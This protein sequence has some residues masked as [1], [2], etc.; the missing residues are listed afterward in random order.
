M[1]NK[2]VISL[3]I[4]FTILTNS[5]G[6]ELNISSSE[7]EYNKNLS[8]WE[9]KKD[10]VIIDSKNNKVLAQEAL[11]DKEKQIITTSGITEVF[12]SDGYY[13]NSSNVVFDNIS[14]TITSNYPSEIKDKEGNLIKLSIFKY[15]ADKNFLFSKG[16]IK[17]LDKNKNVYEL[18]EIFIDA[19]KEKIV[20]TDIKAFLNDISLKANP[21]NEP[22]FFANTILI[23]NE[24][25][26]FNKG[27][28]TYCKDNGKDTCPAWSLLADKIEHD[29]AKKTIYY[30]KAVLKI[31]D[32]PIFY[33]P[34]FAHPD[35]TVKRR[36][37]FLNPAFL[38][39]SNLGSGFSIPYF[40]AIADNKDFTITPRFYTKT[41]PL[42]LTEYRHEFKNSSLKVDFGY[43]NDNYEKSKTGSKGARSHFFS[44]LDTV[45]IN[46]KGTFSDLKLQLQQ[47]TNEKYLK[48]FDIETDL[49]SKKIDILE[50]HLKYQ[51]GKE[52]ILF[53]ANISVFEDLGQPANSDK[54]EYNAKANLNKFLFTDHGN[55]DL[56]S[57][58]E[59]QKVETNKQK[60]VLVNKVDW[61]S[62]YLPEKFGLKTNFLA[63]AVNS[64]YNS[65]HI[66][67]L[68]NDGSQKE[69][70]TSVGYYGESPLIKR[71][72][73]NNSADLLTPKFLLRYSPTHMRRK[74]D[75]R[76]TYL[77][78]FD[79]NKINDLGMI[80]SGTSAT[81]G[82]EYKKYES[83]KNNILDKELV[84]F[85]L[86]QV[87][88]D[89]ANSKMPSS[90][91][92]N[93]R[94]SDI[95]G[96]SKI[97]LN[98]ISEINYKFSLD[99]GFG[100]VHYNEIDTS[101]VLNDAKFNLGYLQEKNHIGNQEYIVSSLDYNLNK[102]NK[103]S[104]S[105]KRN[106]LTSS[107]DYYNLSYEY[108]FDCLKAGLVYRREF[109]DDNDIDSEDTLM[110]Q[111][112]LVPFVNI[113]SPSLK[114][115]K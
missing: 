46:K 28:F 85:S 18:S 35:P 31:F 8:I 2:I 48:G 64:N 77:N 56:K 21:N 6:E 79:L 112:S 80:E 45:L 37:G 88:N 54:Y 3:F 84:S 33:F 82:F 103:F 108:E 101:I 62:K 100:E 26:I 1:K 13:I 57:S 9:L 59:H 44:N 86:G 65:Q 115:G 81:I 107:T 73:N 7:I 52:N 27:V 93:Q 76:L 97:T 4:F 89:T 114:D 11:Y 92:L 66:D 94:F 58:L 10:I 99:Q 5:F 50:N 19:K 29:K 105:T 34:K 109:Y 55:F 104:L 41:D 102:N 30:D 23:N 24:K 61:K 110:F 111:I 63:T 43:V 69:F 87:L 106:I 91:S 42:L 72:L 49:A 53:D 96:Q 98:D 17:I 67:N 78:L 15:Q 71:N 36:S 40:W 113:L 20:G 32:Y 60:E 38:N 14:Q 12:T 75:G 68:K 70:S 83:S 95:V 39:N 16:K 51:L 47:V 74:K 90:M 25:S 22:R